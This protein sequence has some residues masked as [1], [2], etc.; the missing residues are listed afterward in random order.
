MDLQGRAA[1]VT[2]S[3]TGIGAETAKLLAEMGCN[4]VVNY[5]RSKAEAEETADECRQAGADVLL[6]SADVSKDEDCRAMAKA[7]LDKWQR[8][9]VLVNSAGRTKAATPGDY[10]SLSA[11]DFHDVYAVNVVGAYQMIRAVVPTMKAAGNGAIVSVSALAAITGEG[12]SIAYAASK[13]ALNSMTISFAR[14]LAPHIRVNAVC[15]GFVATRWMKNLLGEEKF[16]ERVRGMAET[17]PVGKTAFAEDIAEIVLWYIAG[18]DLITGEVVPVDYG[19]RFGMR[20]P[21]TK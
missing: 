21:A 5:S 10:D 13:G 18:P 16:N 20:T 6:I 7:A 3:A 19:T 11:Q 12:S 15:P 1:I 9:D 2:G 14:Q 4:V 17:T 8:I